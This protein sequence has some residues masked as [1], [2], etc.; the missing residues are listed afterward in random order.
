MLTVRNQEVTVDRITLIA[1]LQANRTSHKENYDAAMIA[2][3]KA[4]TLELQGLAKQA[5]SG[6]FNNIKI[7]S[8]KPRHSLDQY[9][10]VI[11]ML[12]MSVEPSIRLDRESFQSFV[13]DRWHWK[14]AF[15]SLVSSN[16]TVFSKYAG[17]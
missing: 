2:W 4:L 7:E 6:D 10:D 17:D 15:E 16:A 3:Q 11:E 14:S 13:K 5:E 12:Q 1:A 9:D 8:V